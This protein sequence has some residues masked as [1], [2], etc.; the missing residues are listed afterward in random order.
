MAPSVIDTREDHD[1]AQLIDPQ[2]GKPRPAVHSLPVQNVPTSR[3]NLDYRISETPI[4]HRR[5]SR[6]VCMG[7]GYSG[8]MMGI[9]HNEKMKEKNI[10]FVIYE[11]NPDLGGT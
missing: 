11:R 7:A 5:S 1:G 6:V 2:P 10:D 3:A 9:I 4:R 8:L